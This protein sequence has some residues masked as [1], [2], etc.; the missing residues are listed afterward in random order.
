MKN[1]AITRRKIGKR[2][3]LNDDDTKGLMD[4]LNGYFEK[5]IEIPRMKVGNRQTIE[6]L[7]NEEALKLAKCLRNEMRDWIPRMRMPED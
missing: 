2:Q 6:T 3:V 1:E 7:I 4:S 5:Q